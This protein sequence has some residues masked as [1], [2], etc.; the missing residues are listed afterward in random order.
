V[1][2]S[3]R[4]TEPDQ[5][6]AKFLVET[7]EASGHGVFWDNRITVGQKWARVIDER[8]RDANFFVVLISAES[9]RSDMVREEIK[10]AYEMSRRPE[11]PLI[12][13]P[14][15]AAY[16]GDL[17]YDLRAYLNPIQYVV[18]AVKAIPLLLRSRSSKQSDLRK[19]FPKR[20]TPLLRVL[21]CAAF[22]MRQKRRARPFRKR[23]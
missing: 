4:R 14:I 7:L 17:P 16:L 22:S 13:L 3:Y 8:I 19:S 12:I 5:S 18:C 10:L 9:M 11:A 6:V 23:S 2:V 15:R 21:D 20:R 1:F